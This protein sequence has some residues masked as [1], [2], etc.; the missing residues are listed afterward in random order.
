MR[1]IKSIKVA[2][3]FCLQEQS[4]AVNDR[5]ICSVLIHKIIT[6][7]KQH[8]H[9]FQPQKMQWGA[10]VPRLSLRHSGADLIWRPQFC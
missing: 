1:W 8:G 6:S 7:W 4:T 3:A 2:R 10:T 5:T 9:P